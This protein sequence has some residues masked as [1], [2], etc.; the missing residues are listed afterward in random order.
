MAS[1]IGASKIGQYC[2]TKQFA[3]YAFGRAISAEQE[4]CLIRGMGDFV[5]QSGGA[6]RELFTSIAHADSAYTR[7]H[8]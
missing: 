3:E 7:T 8:Q 1:K 5:L 2:F 4:P 6:A